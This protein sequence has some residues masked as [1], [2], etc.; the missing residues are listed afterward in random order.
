[1]STAPSFLLLLFP[2]ALYRN[3]PLLAQFGSKH[4]HIGFRHTSSHLTAGGI[5]I[6]SVLT[7]ATDVR[8]HRTLSV[9]TALDLTF[10]T[11][12]HCQTIT[13]AITQSINQH[14]S[15]PQPITQSINQLPYYI[16][17]RINCDFTGIFHSLSL[18]DSH[19]ILH[20]LL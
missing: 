13:Q 8:A 10:S 16:L 11:C 6:S 7:V 17:Q 12:D 9:F 15:I 20:C 5:F 3:P 18:S 14:F 1:M 2:G 19:F 4:L